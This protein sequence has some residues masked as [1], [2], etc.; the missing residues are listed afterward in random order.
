MPKSKK[1]IEKETIAE[2]KERKRI[3]TSGILSV[4]QSKY[5]YKYGKVNS[6]GTVELHVRYDS[7]GNKTR[8]TEYN[9]SDGKIRTIV[10]FRYDKNGNL[11]EEL[12][13]KDENSFKTVHRYN[14]RNSKIETVSYRADGTVEK[15]ITYVYDETGL[16]LETFGKLDDGRLFMRDSY[17]YDGTGNVIEFKNNLRKFTM[18]YDRN[19]NLTSVLKFQRYF[20]AYDSI[21]Y[22]LNEQFT[23]EYDRLNHLVEMRSYRPDSTQKSRT[24]YVVNESGQNL[25]EREYGSDGRLV[26]SRVLKYD[27]NQNLMEESGSDRT[28]KFKTVYKYD[29]RGNRTEWVEFDQINEPVSVTKVSFSRFGANATAANSAAATV[30][31]SLFADEEDPLNNEEFFQMI[32]SR[33]IAPDGTYLGMV[34]ADTANPQSIINT[35]GQYGFSQSPTSIFNPSIPYGGDNGIFSPFNAQ[36][37][38]PPSIYKDGKFFTYLTEND[39]YRPRTMP[40]KLIEFLKNLAKQ[41]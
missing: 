23:F 31:D 13:K 40:R 10:S 19:G 39:S 14:S 5:L 20:K 30:D 26:Y 28:M 7:K 1:E 6:T 24:Q 32:G 18:E 2:L 16:L 27:K 11:V 38:S 41:N 17:L 12:L 37:P 9:A 21:Q 36:S 15:K 3:V 22:N 34:I 4:T 29:T 35:W 33:V 8:I 25:E